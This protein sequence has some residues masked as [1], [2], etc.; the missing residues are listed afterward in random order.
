MRRLSHSHENRIK[1]LSGHGTREWD[2]RGERGRP[3]RAIA[4]C[5]AGITVIFPCHLAIYIAHCSGGVCCLA[6][7]NCFLCNCLISPAQACRTSKH[8][9][10]RVDTRVPRGINEVWWRW[11]DKCFYLSA[12]SNSLKRSTLGFSLSLLYKF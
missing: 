8:T 5:V 7:L 2:G 12:N 4:L 10:A 6:L 11:S 1:T 9:H 3:H